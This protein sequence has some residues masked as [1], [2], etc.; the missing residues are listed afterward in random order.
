MNDFT[1]YYD[2]YYCEDTELDLFYRTSTHWQ[3]LCYR[4][5]FFVAAI[6]WLYYILETR[7]SQ[8]AYKSYNKKLSKFEN[9][10]FRI[11]SFIHF[12]TMPLMYIL[13][14]RVKKNCQIPKSWRKRRWNIPFWQRPI[15]AISELLTRECAKHVGMIH[16][17]NIKPTRYQKMRFEI[18]NYWEFKF[19]KL[20]QWCKRKR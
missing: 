7:C 15:Y 19:R 8:F 1:D 16:V 20:T 4:H 13:N 14:V 10:T 11:L 12:R 3:R 9:I 5:T 2:T 6:L 17:K 18:L